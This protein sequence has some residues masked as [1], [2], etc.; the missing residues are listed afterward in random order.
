MKQRVSEPKRIRD[1]D[2]G[3]KDGRNPKIRPPNQSKFPNSKH[4]IID[5]RLF[6]K[7]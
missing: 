7:L 2:L 6:M 4:K 3:E 5:H 1:L